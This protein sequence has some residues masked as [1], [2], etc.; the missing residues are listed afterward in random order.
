MRDLG[1]LD[2]NAMFRH[3]FKTLRFHIERVNSRRE[4]Q[5]LETA[6]VVAHSLHLGV[7]GTVR[8]RQFGTRNRR[9]AWIFDSSN[10]ASS[11]GSR[12]CGGN[13]KNQ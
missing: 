4:L 9:A 13:E 1:H 10:N 2:Q 3:L 6:I 8:E 11:G 7:S 12:D 5:K